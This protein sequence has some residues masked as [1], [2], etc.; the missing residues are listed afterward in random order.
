MQKIV[1]YQVEGSRKYWTLKRQK[2]SAYM[3]A[4][5]TGKCEHPP[6]VGLFCKVRKQEYHLALRLTD[7]AR[8]YVK[9]DH[10]LCW[11]ESDSVKH[12]DQSK[13]H[14][15]SLWGRQADCNK[16]LKYSIATNRAVT[17]QCWQKVGLS[18][19]R[20]V[21]EH[22]CEVIIPIIITTSPPLGCLGL[23]LQSWSP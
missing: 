10:T 17:A 2:K 23:F 18:F 13:K 16:V 12:G 22:S 5:Y 15:W 14:S 7:C 4:L 20:C 1:W 21:D 9:Y 6:T 19:I 11:W 8:S 3:R